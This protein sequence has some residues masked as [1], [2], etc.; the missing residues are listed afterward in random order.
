MVAYADLKGIYLLH[1]TVSSAGSVLLIVMPR[2]WPNAWCVPDMNKMDV[3]LM[4]TL[5]CKPFGAEYPYSLRIS[6]S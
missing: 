5:E 3:K 6:L 4:N 2:A 1:Q